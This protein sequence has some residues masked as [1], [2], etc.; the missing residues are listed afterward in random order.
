MK[1]N[2]STIGLILS[3]VSIMFDN[4]VS[5]VNDS[6]LY[7]YV[8]NSPKE[9]GWWI[10]N[11]IR[12]KYFYELRYGH[13]EDKIYFDQSAWRGLGGMILMDFKHSRYN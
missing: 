2:A 11:L 9:F 13:N 12:F 6:N 8:K 7:E 1:L 10:F 3:L 4:G 5:R